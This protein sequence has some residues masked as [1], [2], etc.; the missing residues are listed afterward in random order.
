M[1][2][3]TRDSDGNIRSDPV[4]SGVHFVQLETENLRDSKNTIADFLKEEATPVFHVEEDG[5]SVTS[6]VAKG[7]FADFFLN[8]FFVMDVWLFF[9]FS[10]RKCVQ[11]NLLIVV[12]FPAPLWSKSLATDTSPT[13]IWVPGEKLR[14]PPTFLARKRAWPLSPRQAW[15]AKEVK[16]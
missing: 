10:I 16:R 13:A 15:R 9:F 2:V 11:K 8:C 7:R 6:S 14:K 4:S 1:N 3:E 5:S 12:P